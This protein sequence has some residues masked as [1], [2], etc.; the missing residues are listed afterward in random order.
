MFPLF[1]FQALKLVGE[2][3]LFQS[4]SGEKWKEISELY[5]NINLVLGLEIIPFFTD[6]LSIAIQI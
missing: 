6:V 2:L 5:G 3:L 1:A 4:L